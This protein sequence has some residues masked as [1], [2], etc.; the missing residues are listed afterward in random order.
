[1]ERHPAVPVCK[2]FCLNCWNWAEEVDLEIGRQSSECRPMY[3]PAQC[4]IILWSIADVGRTTS[5]SGQGWRLMKQQD[6]LRI[7]IVGEESYA[8]P[9]I[10]Q[11]EGIER[12]RRR[13]V[14]RQ[15]TLTDTNSAIRCCWTI[16][17]QVSFV[18]IHRVSKKTVPVLFFE[19]LRA[20]VA[21][22]NNFW[23]ATSRRNLT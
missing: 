13:R 3:V 18:L 12:R 15:K 8:P 7:E 19:S 5:L 22:F 17:S 9:T 2:N 10:H 23:C 16:W 4:V 20:T 11:K 14:S 1:M 6:R 21:N